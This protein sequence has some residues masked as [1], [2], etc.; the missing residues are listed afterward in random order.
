MSSRSI[1]G[2]VHRRA[3]LII[4]RS[5]DRANSKDTLHVLR[6]FLCSNLGG[7]WEPDEIALVENDNVGAV[8]ERA[9]GMREAD[10]ALIVFRGDGQAVKQGLPWKEMKLTLPAGDMITE[11]E[12]NPGCPR[13]LQLFD[14]AENPLEPLLSFTRKNNLSSTRKEFDD[15]ILHA[16]SGVAKVQ[17]VARPENPVSSL[18]AALVTATGTWAAGHLG[19]LGI[20]EA[21]MLARPRISSTDSVTYSG[22]RRRGHYPFA[23]NRIS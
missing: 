2:S 1:Q 23:V 7:A 14:C 8:L 12:L 17:L 5:V 15:A 13:C 4:G 3:L 18:V 21:L 9:R 16:E 6:D 19:V 11:R 20:S 10:Y 22:R